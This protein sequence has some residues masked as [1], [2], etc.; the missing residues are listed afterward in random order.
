MDYQIREKLKGGLYHKSEHL[1]LFEDI[2][3]SITS[4]KGQKLDL[5]IQKSLVKVISSEWLGH[6][7]Y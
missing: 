2:I 7:P 4:Q 3:N 5:A 1:D 6:R